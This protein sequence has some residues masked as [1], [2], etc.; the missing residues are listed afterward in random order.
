VNVW[1]VTTEG[2]RILFHTDQQ[3]VGF[4]NATGA[5]FLEAPGN[6]RSCRGLRLRGDALC[7]RY[8]EGNAGNSLVTVRLTKVQGEQAGH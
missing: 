2:S 6:Y 1:S 3:L 8:L 5:C 4:D 7:L